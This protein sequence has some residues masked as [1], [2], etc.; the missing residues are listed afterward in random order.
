MSSRTLCITAGI[1]LVAAFLALEPGCLERR[2]GHEASSEE[3]RC[4]SCHG[5]PSRDGDFLQRSAPPRDLLG[6]LDPGYP[7]I[8]AHLT[9]VYASE[10]HGRVA[11][12]ECHVVPETTE[13]PGHADDPR[14]AEIRFGELAQR[15]GRSASYDLVARR[16]SD[17]YCHRGADAVWTEPRSSIQACGS[18]HGLPPPAPHP[19]SERCEQCH[20][21]VVGT[22]QRIIVPELHVDGTVQ[23]GADAAC[24]A[25][26]GSGTDP[27]PPPDTVGNTAVTAIGVGAHQAHLAGGGFSRALSCAECHIVP[28]TVGSHADGLPA[29][30]TL[31]GVAATGARAP[32]WDRVS[33][34]CSDS[35]CHGPS[36]ASTAPSASWVLAGALSCTSCH[37][38]PPPAPHPQL[39]DCSSCHGDVVAQD[40]RTIVA[41]SRHVDGIVDVA[42]DQRCTACHGSDNP[43]PPLDLAGQS[44]TTSLSVG[45]HQTHVTGTARARPVPCAECHLV[46]SSVFEPGHVDTSTPAEVTFSGAAIAF[47][48]APLYSGGTCQGTSCHGGAFPSGHASGGSNTM[49]VWTNVDGSETACGA[50]HGLPPP[51]PHPR[52]DLN[53]ICSACHENIAA[54]NIGFLRPE[55]HVDGVV[56]FTLP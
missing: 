31:L 27:A 45:A 53:P 13:S 55:L 19:Q 38:L 34:S 32:L 4:A 14:P 33:A 35:W 23:L 36:P 39:T 6:V 44:S 5:E 9:H 56:T 54:D 12:S 37:G 15:G 25:C 7:G 49:P 11:C 18:C 24:T 2:E 17:T 8:G 51:A 29:E 47:G 40:D 21:Q 1:A 52:G 3:A 28:A 30:V 16:C 26:H 10:T 48:G 46:P 20:G 50:C 41:R 43:A 22:N 42:L